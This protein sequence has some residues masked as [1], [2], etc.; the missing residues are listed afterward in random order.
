MRAA[1]TRS[2][3]P[4]EVVEIAELPTPVPKPGEVLVRVTA[5]GVTRGD[6][7][8]RGLDVPP[9]YGTLV[10]LAFG[11]RRPRRPVMG[12]E[13]AGV[14]VQSAGGFEVGQ[15]VMGI[16]GLKGGAHADYLTIAADG[17]VLPTPDSLS[18]TEAAAFFFGG[19]TAACFLIDKGGLRAGERLLING[20]GGAVGSAA[21]QIA[22]GIGAQVTARCSPANAPLA[23]R[24]GAD[25]VV[26]R[27]APLPL[28]P[29]DVVLDA[30]G[31]LGFA[32]AAGILAPDG[33]F[34][35]IVSSLWD[36]MHDALRP[37]RG[38]RRVVGGVVAETRTAM[39]RLLALHG[40][41]GYR[42]V[43]GQ[44]FGFGEIRAAHALA[45]SGA[46]QGNVV[47]TMGASGAG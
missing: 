27:F 42:P 32:E 2:Y 46:K 23:L 39:L 28:G 18:D 16:T 9:G 25:A 8:V 17:L 13:F 7:R 4:P 22:R 21:V 1:L 33:R 15:R 10:R 43:V 6:A 30:A 19:L 5:A 20:A 12:A 40:S 45:G 26:D 36:G 14:V 24:L 29:F 37:R 41:G 3:G 31:A 47:V 35:R 34:L 11:L 38:Q 44:V